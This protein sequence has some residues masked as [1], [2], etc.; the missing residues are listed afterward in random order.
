MYVIDSDVLIDAIRFHPP[1]LDFLDGL[2][3]GQRS[4]AIITQFELLK[5]CTNKE[6]EARLN[7]FLRHF[8]VLH[9]T[10][11]VEKTAIELFRVK[12]W[13]HGIGIADS[14]IA[15]TALVNKCQLV[16]RNVKHYRGI[17]ALKLHTP[18]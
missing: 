17:Q 18:Y 3:K 13:S 6:Q 15:A 11:S 2:S 8:G 10:S 9:I 5:G 1:A 4:I 16:T 14:F 12:R 7:R